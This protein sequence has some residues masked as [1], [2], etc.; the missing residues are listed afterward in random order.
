M[1][2]ASE[3]PGKNLEYIKSLNRTNMLTI[4]LALCEDEG[5]AKQI[6]AKAKDLLSDVDA[7]EIEEQVFDALNTIFIEELWKN[8]GKDYFGGYHDETE[9]AY[10]MVED[11]VSKPLQNMK[12][13]RAL[14]MKDIEKKYCVG[15]VAGLLRY[16]DEGENEFHEAVPDDP[17]TI[18]DDVFAEWKEHNPPEEWDEVK[19]TFDRFAEA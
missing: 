1:K 4:L 8:S 5:L 10:E 7:G 3:T 11:A 19:A 15:I 2:D 17:Y 14:G 12:R 18:A 9:V 6:S 13:Y 16:G